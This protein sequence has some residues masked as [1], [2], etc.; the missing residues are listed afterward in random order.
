MAGANEAAS[1]STKSLLVGKHDG[2]AENHLN[3]VALRH[4]WTRN[5]SI[6]PE[7]VK[8]LD[9]ETLGNVLEVHTLK[10]RPVGVR[11]F[12]ENPPDSG[13]WSKIRAWKHDGSLQSVLVQAFFEE[14][15]RDGV[16]TRIEVRDGADRAAEGDTMSLHSV[17]SRIFHP[18][19]SSASHAPSAKPKPRGSRIVSWLGLGNKGRN[20]PQPSVPQGEDEAPHEEQELLEVPQ[21]PSLLSLLRP[22]P[23]VQPSSIRRSIFDFFRS[24]PAEPA[25]EP[26]PSS[27]EQKKAEEEVLRKRGWM[28]PGLKRKH[29]SLRDSLRNGNGNPFL[30]NSKPF[31]VGRRKKHSAPENPFADEHAQNG[32]AGPLELTEQ[33][34]DEFFEVERPESMVLMDNQQGPDGKSWS[35][36]KPAKD[37]KNKKKKGK[38]KALGSG[39]DVIATP[40][41]AMPGPVQHESEVD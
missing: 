11:I 10:L 12:V 14:R 8:N 7:E 1:A 22:K 4:G 6:T 21:K 3:C 35:R 17:A 18:R 26:E 30:G 31:A 19:E 27:E 36:F 23:N 5:F 28:P 37:K 38:G 16:I 20:K 25:P 9:Y 41:D 40:Q 39:A 32:D 13:N 29:R 2:H 15:R 33:D 34:I 24:R